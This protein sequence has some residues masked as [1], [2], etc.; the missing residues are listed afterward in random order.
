[1]FARVLLAGI[2]AALLAAPVHAQRWL[3]FTEMLSEIGAS[4][5]AREV[6]ASVASRGGGAADVL[7]GLGFKVES[8]AAAVKQWQSLPPAQL[9]AAITRNE[10]LTRRFLTSQRLTMEDRQLWYSGINTI[11]TNQIDLHILRSTDLSR[12]LNRHGLAE[13][14][15]GTDDHEPTVRC[16]ENCRSLLR[17]FGLHAAAAGGVSSTVPLTTYMHALLKRDTDKQETNQQ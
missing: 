11:R 17:D 6:A 10:E 8:E 9:G 4:P 14:T 2:I 13:V 15:I 12:S 3:R 16:D 5:A 1:M 7:K